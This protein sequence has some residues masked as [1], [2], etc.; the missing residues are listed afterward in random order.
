M[1]EKK[2]LD[3]ARKLT[4]FYIKGSAGDSIV[5]FDKKDILDTFGFEDDIHA[6]IFQHPTG[7]AL[8]VHYAC[9]GDWTRALLLTAESLDCKS[10]ILEALEW[11][12][13]I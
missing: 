5:L 11:F 7:K 1:E 2:L 8:L 4:N 12:L 10:T 6:T 3:T 9:E 13:K